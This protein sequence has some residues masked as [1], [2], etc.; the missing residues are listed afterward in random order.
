MPKRL[1]LVCFE[2]DAER[3]GVDSKNDEAV[4]ELLRQKLNF[5]PF[6]WELLQY[7]LDENIGTEENVLELL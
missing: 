4:I 7:S 2:I 5:Q 6:S 1:A 3:Y